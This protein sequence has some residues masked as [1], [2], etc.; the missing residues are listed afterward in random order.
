M[1]QLQIK[2]ANLA[3]IEKY[4]K[5]RKLP[6]R[7]VNLS[8]NKIVDLDQEAF[9]VEDVVRAGVNLDEVVK[10]LIVR[11]DSDPST[12]FVRSGHSTLR[13]EPSGSDSKRPSGFAAFALRGNDRFNL[14]RAGRVCGSK[15]KLAKPEEVLKV[16]GV[17]VGAVCPIL[18]GIPIYVDRKVTEFENVH[19]GSGD[20]KHGLEMKLSDLLSAVGEY[21]VLDLV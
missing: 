19:M 17:S 7:L 16:V 13:D 14:K 11:V 8:S 6:C 2:M 1:G 5:Q 10:T 4:L 12:H 20:L 3:Q 9:T 15:S 21:K 18:V